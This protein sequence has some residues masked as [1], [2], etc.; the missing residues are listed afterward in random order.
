MPA[1]A[2]PG[3]VP[4]KGTAPAGSPAGTYE[5]IPAGR[6]RMVFEDDFDDNRRK[7]PVGKIDLGTMDFRIKGGAYILRAVDDQGKLVYRD[8]IPLDETRDFEIEARLRH[9]AGTENMG[10][11][12]FWGRSADAKSLQFGI[13]GNGHYQ[14]LA[15]LGATSE[16]VIP[17]TKSEL[18]KKDVPNTLTVR[19]VGK[20]YYFFLNGSLVHRMPFRPFA[21]RQI[22]FMVAKRATVSVDSLRIS[23]LD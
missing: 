2:V 10:H 8:D 3:V 7:W 20:T 5:G 13:T 6:K 11:F 12:L 4:L 9:V 19:K 22:G 18:V 21:G 1:A 17:W 16:N 23:Y 15:G 14:V